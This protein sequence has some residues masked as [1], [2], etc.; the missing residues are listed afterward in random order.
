MSILYI[1]I[2]GALGSVVRYL[3][4][5]FI[6]HYAG[7]GFPLGTLLVNISGSML[8]GIFIGWLVIRG[9]F[10]NAQDLRLFVAVGILGGYTTFSS[11]S[12][13]AITLLEQ[14]RWGAMSAYILSSVLFSLAGLMLGLRLMRAFA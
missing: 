6:G 10:A 2:G 7:D 4:Q 14:G 5:S 13:D 3:M 11:F 1:A 8:M 12:L 9:T